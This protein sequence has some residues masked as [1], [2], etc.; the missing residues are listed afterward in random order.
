[1][2]LYC[3]KNIYFIKKKG[4]EHINYKEEF[5]EQHYWIIQCERKSV[6][7]LMAFLTSNTVRRH[8]CT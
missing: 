4:Q 6:Q 3:R 1:M 5:I 8:S 2:D 7:N